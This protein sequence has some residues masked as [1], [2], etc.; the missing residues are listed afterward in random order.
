MLSHAPGL[1]PAFLEYA[2]L[3]GRYHDSVDRGD[4]IN[5]AMVKM[6][7]DHAAKLVLKPPG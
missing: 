4:T 7:R 3:A 1:D 6:L 5:D 2:D